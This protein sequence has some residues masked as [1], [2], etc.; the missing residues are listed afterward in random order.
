MTTL[1]KKQVKTF[2]YDHTA[3]GL[4]GNNFVLIAKVRHDDECGNGHNTFSI[5]GELYDRAR[6]PGEA[7]IKHANGTTYYLGSCGC[8]HEDIAKYFPQLAPLLK[9]HGCSTDGP[10]YYLGNTIYQAGD[11]DYSGLRKG[12]TKP[13]LSGGKPGAFNW[14]LAAI[15]EKGEEVPHGHL[16]SYV[17]APEKPTAV[18]RCEWR[19]HVIE[20]KGKERDLNAARHCAIW[21]EATDEQ[22]IAPREEL[23]AALTARLPA[24]MAEF[25]AA[26]ESLGFTY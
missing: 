2:R 18:Y 3:R 4:S 10:M 8:I 17:D 14:Y 26:V 1:T 7:S 19:Q 25:R 11:R 16:P 23:E 9:W 6:I 15:D 21:P 12:E 5:T 20:G 13:L 24:L 22:L